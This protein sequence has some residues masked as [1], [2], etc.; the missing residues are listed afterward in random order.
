[1]EI[2]YEAENLNISAHIEKI[3]YTPDPLIHRAVSALPR[4]I[5]SSIPKEV[6]SA[7]LTSG[8]PRNP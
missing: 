6:A 8:I 5:V 2:K 4:V 1:M 3:N 7:V